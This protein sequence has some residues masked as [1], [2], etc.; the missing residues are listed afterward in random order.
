MTC[1]PVCD[2]LVLGDSVLG[3]VLVVANSNLLSNTSVQLKL[4]RAAT[5]VSFGVLVLCCTCGVTSTSLGG[6]TTTVA[7]SAAQFR[8]LLF[9]CTT[10]ALQCTWIPPFQLQD[11]RLCI[12]SSSSGLGLT[13]CG[14]TRDCVRICQTLTNLA[15]PVTAIGTFQTLTNLA[16]PVTHN[17]TGCGCVILKVTGCLRMIWLGRIA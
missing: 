5:L 17:A 1:V 9:V 13:I 4:F 15:L 7:S 8:Q 6:G 11:A 3:H 10:T 14:C 2:G 12:S 16:L